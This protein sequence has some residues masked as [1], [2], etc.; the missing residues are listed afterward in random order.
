ML[1]AD[2]AHNMNQAVLDELNTLLPSVQIV[3]PQGWLPE[4][5]REQQA[6]QQ[7]GQAAAPAQPA[8]APAV[9]GR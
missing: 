8:Q 5:L 2:A 6:A 1:N 7:Q 9:Q 4:E 3:P